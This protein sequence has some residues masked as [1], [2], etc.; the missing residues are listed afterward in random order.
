MLVLTRKKNQIILIGND[1]QVMVTQIDNYQVKLGITAP[2]DM[3]I[4]REE[5]RESKNKENEVNTP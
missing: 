2:K 3:A 5:I 1:I 4:D